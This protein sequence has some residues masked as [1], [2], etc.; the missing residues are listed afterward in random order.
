MCFVHKLKLSSVPLDI[1]LLTPG[2]YVPLVENCCYKWIFSF[3]FFTFNS[4]LASVILTAL[5]HIQI[6]KGANPINMNFKNDKKCY[7]YR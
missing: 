1:S 6:N 2:V 7:K 5:L 4:N 3:L